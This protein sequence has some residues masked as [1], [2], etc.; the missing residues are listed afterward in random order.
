[1]NTNRATEVKCPHCGTECE[2]NPDEKKNTDFT[3]GNCNTRFSVEKARIGRFMHLNTRK[4]QIV[5]TGV[6][7]ALCVFL[8]LCIRFTFLGGYRLIAAAISAFIPIMV[9]QGLK[10][11]YTLGKF[12]IGLLAVMFAGVSIN[13]YAL[14][15]LDLAHMPHVP[16]IVKSLLFASF[17]V[18]LF[19][20]LQEHAKMR[21]IKRL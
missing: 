12:V 3:C 13:F 15:D 8:A 19:Y 7:I 18:F 20:C 14:E 21:K 1:M 11:G 6:I 10:F 9:Y 2:L 16:F 17:V 5:T 4:E